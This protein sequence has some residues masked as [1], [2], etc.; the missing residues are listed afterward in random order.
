MTKMGIKKNRIVQR[1]NS[2]CTVNTLKKFNPDTTAV[3]YLFGKKDAGS[4]KGG[5][6]KSGGKTYYQDFKKN[7]NNLEG[8][9]KHGYY[10]T[11]PHT[12]FG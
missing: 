5:T 10:I 11:A 7:K 4:F 1:E 3:V 9:E 6:K 2:V 8:F 12:R